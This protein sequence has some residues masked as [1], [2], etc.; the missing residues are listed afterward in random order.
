MNRPHQAIPSFADTRIDRGDSSCSFSRTRLLVLAAWAGRSS[1][2]TKD[3][4]ENE[5]DEA[6]I[7][8][9]VTESGHS[10]LNFNNRAPKGSAWEAGVKRASCWGAV[11]RCVF[12]TMIVL[13]GYGTTDAADRIVLRDLT[14][15][16]DAKVTAMSLDGVKLE[17]GKLIG[18]DEIEAGRLDGNRQTL[19]DKYLKNVGVHLFRIRQRMANGDYRSLSP[20]AEAIAKYYRGRDSETAYLV[21]QAQ[22]WGRIAGGQRAAA[23][24]PYLYCFEYLRKHATEAVPLPGDRR[25]KF[26]PATGLCEELPPIWFDGEAAK[27]ALPAVAAAIAKLQE[28]RPGAAR[29]YYAS[30]AIAAGDDDA[31]TRA[32]AGIGNDNRRLAELKT[33]LEA[34]REITS[35]SP[36]DQT[37]A[38]EKM[39]DELDAG[40]RPLAMYWL[41]VAKVGGEDPSTQREGVLDLLHLPAVHGEQSPELAAAGLYQAMQVLEELGDLRGSIALRSELLSKYGQTY[42]AAKL[43]SDAAN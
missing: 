35:G 20:S 27:D 37:T 26:D 34:Q 36:A 11:K 25:L 43:S 8:H 10:N 22:M 29:I 13:L 17:D 24:E 31:A 21:M 41:G 23:V 39:R 28:P 5:D 1:S 9:A 30:L 3:E 7:N 38:L 14:I 32:L 33:I 42:H 4:Y 2:S 6:D 12:V 40:N 15:I 16:N 19:F 18:W